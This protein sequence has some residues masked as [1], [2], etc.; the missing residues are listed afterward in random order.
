MSNLRTLISALRSL[1]LARL[2]EKR[3]T[4]TAN[5]KALG[6]FNR[7][8]WRHLAADI[9]GL[10]VVSQLG[11]RISAKDLEPLSTIQQIAELMLSRAK[12]KPAAKAKLA[13]DPCVRKSGTIRKKSPYLGGSGL[14][15]PSRAE[16][17]TGGGTRLVR[18]GRDACPGEVVK[19]PSRL[20]RPSETKTLTLDGDR[21]LVQFG[22]DDE[23]IPDLGSNLIA[24]P[25][26]PNVL[27]FPVEQRSEFDDRQSEIRLVD[28]D[29]GTEWNANCPIYFDKQWSL[30]IAI[31]PA[32]EIGGLPA[33]HQRRPIFLPLMSQ[34]VELLI[35]LTDLSV[36]GIELRVD[37]TFATLELPPSGS[38]VPVR[39]SFTPVI[40]GELQ[41]AGASCKARLLVQIFYRLNLVDS[42]DVDLTV[43]AFQPTELEPMPALAPRPVHMI[44]HR[45]DEEDRARALGWLGDDV[46]PRTMVISVTSDA[47][48]T[49]LDFTIRQTPDSTPDSPAK[50]AV[51]DTTDLSVYLS[52]NSFV[53]HED[54]NALLIDVRVAYTRL[55][56]K[57]FGG[58]ATSDSSVCQSALDDLAKL[59]VRA[60][61]LLFNN[62]AAD[63]SLVAVGKY[64]KQLKLPNRSIIQIVAS[65]TIS[66]FVFP[67]ALLYDDDL[68]AARPA[69]WAGFWGARY[70]IEQAVR[71]SNRERPQP[72]QALDY[73]YLSWKQFAE[74]ENLRTVLSRFI[75]KPRVDFLGD[76]T[77]ADQLIDAI[78]DDRINF[79]CFF[80]HG[81][82]QAPGDPVFK[83]LL[84]RQMQIIK[85]V[86]NSLALLGDEQAPK[87]QVLKDY[88]V[89]LRELLRS[90]LAA[91]DHEIKFADIS[92]QYQPFAAL[93]S[94]LKFH[95]QPVLLMNMCQSAQLFPGASEC[96]VA[97][98]L[99]LKAAAVIGTE[100]EISP[101]LG[102]AF[103]RSFI[104]AMMHDGT[105][106]GEALLDARNALIAQNNP[107]GL[108]YT[109]YGQ[110][111]RSLIPKAS[112][113]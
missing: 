102:E 70:Q 30:D 32:A 15:I 37:Q 72:S 100:C 96:F 31:R 34:P 94:N 8:G 3:I 90:N 52:A 39:L 21:L 17:E 61:R 25:I 99:K 48:Q 74:S 112:P 113:I 75:A 108:V 51:G 54:L 81:H 93:V 110:A 92:I 73:T 23:P 88:I 57:S 82:T 28:P 69:Q 65:K 53:S 79:Y 80:C 111:T 67:W 14:T 49:T 40:N 50:R 66:D 41:S 55:I 12:S 46:A 1:F 89:T 36:G 45:E 58:S 91:T 85:D 105:T 22:R 87:R 16:S 27:A 86:E 78:Q 11:L 60:W 68:G 4:S 77:S 13:H 44:D 35:K 71:R 76:I 103:G 33:E 101:A 5:V 83:G 97:L 107:L 47:T 18:S 24:A 59:G 6:N 106:V 42:I 62:T 2:S 38:S 98:F 104:A 95:S 43:V 26:P 9:N 7:T 63:D 109:L 19:L 56:L 20:R 64:L 29:S 10:P 84:D